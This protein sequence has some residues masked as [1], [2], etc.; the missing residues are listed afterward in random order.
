M[1]ASIQVSN[2]SVNATCPSSLM[3]LGQPVKTRGVP[4]KAELNHHP[5]SPST[6]RSQ[7]HG[8]RGQLKKEKIQGDRST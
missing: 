2:H 1:G 5:T 7:T 8:V 6:Q 4:Q 3:I